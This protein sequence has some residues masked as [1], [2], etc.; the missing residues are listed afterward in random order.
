M[1]ILLLCGVMDTSKIGSSLVV[2][3][4]DKSARRATR[5]RHKL[6]NRFVY[7]LRKGESVQFWKR[8]CFSGI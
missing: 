3:L 7:T 1:L 8:I 5:M 6:Q 4:Q 2:L